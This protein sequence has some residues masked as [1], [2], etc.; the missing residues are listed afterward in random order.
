MVAVVGLPLAAAAQSDPYRADVRFSNRSA[1]RRVEWGTAT[2]PFPE[3]VWTTG[4]RFGIVG[5]TS[6]ELEP[7]G[8]RWPDGSVRFA[9][10]DVK[11]DI[12]AGA[13]TI[14]TVEEGAPA[15]TPQPFEFGPMANERLRNFDMQFVVGI[16]GRGPVSVNLVGG[17]PVHTSHARV[18]ILYRQRLPGTDFTVDTWLTF[19]RGQDTAHFETR[20]TFANAESPEW[21]QDVDYVVVGVRDAIPSYRNAF[22]HRTLQVTSTTGEGLSFVGLRNGDFWYDG[23]SYEWRGEL[24]FYAADASSPEHQVEAVST[25]LAAMYEPLKGI[26]LNW[27]DS[28]AFGPFGNVPDFPSW[29]TDGGVGFA[30][31]RHARFQTIL[32]SRGDPWE[33][34]ELGLRKDPGTTGDQYDFGA[35][36][37]VD[38][39]RSGLT[40]RIEEARYSA[41]E[42]AARP[43]HH[44]E[45]NGDPLTQ[46]AHPNWVAWTGRS[47][48]NTVVCPDRL[49]KPHPEPF[50]GGAAHGWNAKDRQH[51]SSLTLASAYLLTCS[52]SLAHELFVEAEMFKSSL[53]LPS[54]KPGWSTN[55][56]G[57]PRGTGR[58]YNS[59]AWNYLCTG[60]ESL[61]GW[62]QARVDEVIRPGILALNPAL[63][64][65]VRPAGSFAPDARILLVEHWRPWEDAQAVIG[66]EAAGL[67]LDSEAAHLAAYTVS[68]TLATHGWH[69]DSN[70]SIVAVGIRWIPDGT[71]LTENELT[72]PAN[73]VWSHQT[74]FS[75]WSLSA[76]QIAIRLGVDNGDSDL[77]TRARGILDDLRAAR[78]PPRDNGWDR[79]AG[80]EYGR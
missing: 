58:T 80:W 17:R 46:A 49:G 75:E 60:N 2:V 43:M 19:F 27:P 3:G 48:F 57:A 25:Q 15:P 18:T 6:Y 29:I 76:T 73:V 77:V 79:F 74:G 4:E 38:I 47:H 39:F 45:S 68:K 44:R 31:R 50:L 22:R 70:G 32:S 65:P 56:M 11:L 8:A 67:V 78:R 54:Q 20:L 55:S 62:M 40:Q 61:R 14:V 5:D 53:T 35:A 37:L 59:M 52:D 9:R 63:T 36:K 69:R 72:D 71:E 30:N 13:E 26:A 24:L 51:W 12:P 28:G 16:P 10:L 64:G 23:Q 1:F 34:R 66:L 33:D 41:G 7:F 42:E 21:R